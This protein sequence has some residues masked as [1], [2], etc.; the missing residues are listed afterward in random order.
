MGH[1]PSESRV[2]RWANKKR[3]ALRRDGRSLTACNDTRAA[4]ARADGSTSARAR[5]ACV[6][7]ASDADAPS[8]PPLGLLALP[9]A[10]P[11]AARPAPGGAKLRSSALATA[12]TPPQL[13]NHN[14]KV[15]QKFGD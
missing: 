3:G 10:R 13:E 2:T 7:A 1:T 6:A 15:K 11:A 9:G 14:E 8:G 5:A 12:A 4:D